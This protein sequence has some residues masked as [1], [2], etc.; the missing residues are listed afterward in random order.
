MP[1]HTQVRASIE[2]LLDGLG[3]PT[4]GPL[5]RNHDGGRLS[6]WTINAMVCALGTVARGSPSDDGEP[7]GPHVL[8]HIFGTDLTRS[9]MDV[10]TV[11]QSMGHK[12]LN[13]TRRHALPTEADMEV[14]VAPNPTDD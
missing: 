11:A 12:R 14:A 13:T 8:R 5:T 2:A 3:R 4:S 6:T 7:F 1:L 9:G 10:T